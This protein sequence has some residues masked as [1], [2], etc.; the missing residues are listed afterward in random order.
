M[1]VHA[2]ILLTQIILLLTHKGARLAMRTHNLSQR[3]APFATLPSAVVDEHCARW[4]LGVLV[5]A[6]AA[7]FLRPLFY[8]E[9]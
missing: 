5:S 4:N 7:T 1:H 2:N 9:R 3:W 6:D 8:L